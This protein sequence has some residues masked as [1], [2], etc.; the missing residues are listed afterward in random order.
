MPDVSSYSKSFGRTLCGPFNRLRSAAIL[1]T[2]NS[3]DVHND[4][5]LHFIGFM[6]ELFYC[7][8]E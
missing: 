6:S 7:H 8:K 4:L 1:S 2:G 3:L 5:D